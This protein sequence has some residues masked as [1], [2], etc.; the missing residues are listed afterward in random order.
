[1]KSWENGDDA[2]SAIEMLKNCKLYIGFDSGATHLASF[3][4]TNTFA[5]RHND[6]KFYLDLVKKNKKILEC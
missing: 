2:S 6:A 4:G 1:M 3:L 5:F